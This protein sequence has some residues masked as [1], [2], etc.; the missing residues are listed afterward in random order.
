MSFSQYVSTGAFGGK[1]VVVALAS[2]FSRRIIKSDYVAGNLAAGFPQR[3]DGDTLML[4][5]FNGGLLF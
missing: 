4:K 2:A 1:G 5:T 3:H